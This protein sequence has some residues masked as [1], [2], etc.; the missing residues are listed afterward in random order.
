MDIEI[1][2]ILDIPQIMTSINIDEMN[3][4]HDVVTFSDNEIWFPKEN[5]WTI[6][7]FKSIDLVGRKLTSSF[8]NK[9]HSSSRY[10][11]EI[12]VDYKKKSM[13]GNSF[14]SSTMLFAGPKENVD[15]IRAHLL[16]RLGFKSNADFGN[17]KE[18][19]IRLLNL[20]AMGIKEIDLLLPLVS[21]D[22]DKLRR[23]F[24]TLQK[25]K[26]VDDYAKLTP[27]GLEYLEKTKGNSKSEGEL[28]L[29]VTES[30]EGVSNTWKH[31]NNFKP[32]NNL[33]RF[34]KKYRSSSLTGR[35]ASEDMW[36]YIRGPEVSS[37]NIEKVNE[38]Q[39]HLQIRTI[40]NAGVIIEPS[41]NSL[42]LN[43]KKILDQNEDLCIRIL[44]CLYLG[45]LKDNDLVNILYMDPS[46]L[47]LNLKNLLQDDIIEKDRSITQ[48]GMNIIFND[49]KKEVELYPELNC[50]DL[51]NIEGI[52]IK[53]AKKRLFGK[54]GEL[55]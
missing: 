32:I 34:T 15:L 31:V 35:V 13:F 5:D 3:W 47:N 55:V 27:L 30:F 46:N 4:K 48:K 53:E 7:P 52:K 38:K 11:H 29:N 39:L 24:V 10:T 42:T 45:I 12:A 20:L 51:L 43:M 16:D 41:D 8:I 26:M 2:Y 18:E 49:L 17:L 40:S 37:L 54:L 9:I 1:S 22:K 36:Q 6:I 50:N 25:M 23:A 33:H 19:E 21:Q 14:V 28:G 44:N